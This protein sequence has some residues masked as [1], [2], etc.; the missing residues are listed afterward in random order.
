MSYYCLT[1]YP[2]GLA[3]AKR[4][5]VCWVARSPESRSDFESI[6]LLRHPG[7]NYCGSQEAGYYICGHD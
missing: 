6:E 7:C 4:S 2:L 5:Y 1:R 3:N